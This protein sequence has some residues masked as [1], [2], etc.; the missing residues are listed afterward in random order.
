MQTAYTALQARGFVSARHVS[1]RL[2]AAADHDVVWPGTLHVLLDD[3]V[4]RGGRF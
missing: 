2:E 1:Q 4:A 3:I